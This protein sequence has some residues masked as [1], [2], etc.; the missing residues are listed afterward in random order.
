MRLQ[1]RGWQYDALSAVSAV[2]YLYL[3]AG[4]VQAFAQHLH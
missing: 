1:S 2:I 3:F 4:L